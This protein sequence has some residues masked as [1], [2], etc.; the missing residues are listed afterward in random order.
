MQLP[1]QQ[2][3][4]V[5]A[6]CKIAA[7]GPLLTVRR[8]DHPTGLDLRTL[9]SAHLAAWRTA[10]HA[11][12]AHDSSGIKPS[13]DAQGAAPQSARAARV[14]RDVQ[15]ATA[16]AAAALVVTE[17][18]DGLKGYATRLTAESV[19]LDHPLAAWC[20][21]AIHDSLSSRKQQAKKSEKLAL[22]RAAQ[23][24][25]ALAWA[26]LA[27]QPVVQYLTDAAVAALGEHKQAG[28]NMVADAALHLAHAGTLS[29]HYFFSAFIL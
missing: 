21:V 19:P 23:T 28:P 14:W 13:S 8:L 22:G 11:P 15:R 16:R 2:I 18:W 10:C 3:P 6:K 12:S 26:G 27:S 5:F 25:H 1:L 20:A 29:L 4:T 7:V 17:T 9:D 24:A